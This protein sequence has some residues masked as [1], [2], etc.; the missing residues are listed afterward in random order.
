MVRRCCP[1][2]VDWIATNDLTV[3]GA[4]TSEQSNFLFT[5]VFARILMNSG[6][7]SVTA[8]FAQSNVVAY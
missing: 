8:Q 2:A 3:V 1:A 5:P 6:N 7:G 4:T